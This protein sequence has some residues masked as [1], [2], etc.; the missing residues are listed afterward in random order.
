MKNDKWFIIKKVIQEHKKSQTLQSNMDDIKTTFY[1][2]ILPES[3]CCL[4]DSDVSQN[5]ESFK[6]VKPCSMEMLETKDGLGQGWLKI[7]RLKFLLLWGPLSC[8]G[9]FEF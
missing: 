1:E 3:C 8:K 5:F 2:S 7:R 9:I 4:W 6:I